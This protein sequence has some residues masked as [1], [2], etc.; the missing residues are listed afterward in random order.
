M[1]AHSSPSARGWFLRVLPRATTVLAAVVFLAWGAVGLRCVW[2]NYK[3]PFHLADE[4]ASE[5]R[6]LFRAVTRCSPNWRGPLGGVVF[7]S[8]GEPFSARP[9]VGSEVNQATIA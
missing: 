7:F 4:T 2:L 5:P 9:S 8:Q 6:I 3:S 1:N